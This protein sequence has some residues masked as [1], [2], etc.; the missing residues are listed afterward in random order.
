M[1]RNS[2]RSIRREAVGAP[3]AIV[4]N[5]PFGGRRTPCM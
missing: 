5:G 2:M 1:I 4:T 3:C